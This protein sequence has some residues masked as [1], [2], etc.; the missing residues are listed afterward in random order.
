L[1][2]SGLNALLVE[3]MSADSHLIPNP[4][5]IIKPIS[6]KFARPRQG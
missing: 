2:T 4:R 1:R 6:V 3:A 5:L